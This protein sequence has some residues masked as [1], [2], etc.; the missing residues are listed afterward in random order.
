M[1]P[2]I[3]DFAGRSIYNGLLKS[4]NGMTEKREKT[5]MAEPFAGRAMEF[6]DLSGTMS[7]CIKSSDDSHANVLS[8][9]VTFSLAVK[10]ST[11]AGS[12][13]YYSLSCAITAS[14][15]NGA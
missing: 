12:W 2:E 6:V 11:D 1:H 7:T 13:Y 4:A 14:T 5:V 3:A 15:C 8:A 9:F 10:G